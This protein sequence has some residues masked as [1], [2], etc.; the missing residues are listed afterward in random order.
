MYVEGWDFSSPHAVA[1]EYT[2]GAE[3]IIS[4]V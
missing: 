4:S 3:N 2:L 1:K